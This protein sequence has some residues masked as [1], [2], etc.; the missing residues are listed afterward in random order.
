MVDIIVPAWLCFGRLAKERPHMIK[1]LSLFELLRYGFSGAIFIAALISAKLGVTDA[2]KNRSWPD[3]AIMA[4]VAL[5]VGCLIYSLH[6]VLYRII[7]IKILLMMLRKKYPIAKLPNDTSFLEVEYLR[8][9]ERWKRRCT[10]SCFQG[11]MDEWA[12][13]VHFLYC[14][15]WAAVA[16][17]FVGRVL[18]LRSACPC[19]FL[20]D[21]K[22]RLSALGFLV[23]AV[24]CFLA[25]LCQ[26]YVLAYYDRRLIADSELIPKDSKKDE[27]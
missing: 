23:F 1:S 7:I 16:G 11:H 26:N 22:A 15:A 13:Q 24:I 17:V 5:V 9:F 8:D 12:A 20:C 14:S 6:R 19:V 3:V 25:A 18:L 10:S 4:A 27:A 2:L 21:H